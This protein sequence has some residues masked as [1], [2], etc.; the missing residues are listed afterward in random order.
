M[1]PAEKEVTASLSRSWLA[2]KFSK[3]RLAKPDYSQARAS[4]KSHG[5]AENG[6]I[7]IELLRRWIRA[8]VSA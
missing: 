1:T 4:L 8:N 6:E 5:I 2:R 7:R 3:A